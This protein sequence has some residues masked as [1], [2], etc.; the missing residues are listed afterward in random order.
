MSSSLN[1]VHLAVRPDSNPHFLYYL[2]LLFSVT[3]T[4]PESS[5]LWQRLCSPIRIQKIAKH[6]GIACDFLVIYVSLKRAQH[7]HMESLNGTDGI[8]TNVITI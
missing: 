1:N 6:C 4:R 8:Y 3:C 5:G 7:M 2:V